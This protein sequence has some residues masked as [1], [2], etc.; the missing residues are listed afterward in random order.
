MKSHKQTAWLN[1]AAWQERSVANGPGERFVL[2]LQ[3][4]PF[5]CPG[6]FNQD[7]L[8]FVKRD[9]MSVEEVAAKVLALSGIEG[10]TYS[11]GEPMAQARGLYYLSRRLRAKGLT[12][13]CYSGYTL[14]ELTI[15]RNPWVH[16]LLGCIDM[17][18]DG[19]YDQTQQANLP[20]R[21][22]R[23]QQVHFLTDVYR[24][25]EGQVNQPG[26]EVEFIIG[27]EGFVSTGIF[28]QEFV[29]RLEKILKEGAP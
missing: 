2:W 3:G 24:H 25:L 13:V 20:W 19:R 4:C 10:V 22:S 17:L 23:N 14:E 21:G 11:G 15:I 28:N 7:F 18:I 26:G 12:V 6:C 9:R 27:R 29:R 16:R 8:P 1:V 5:R